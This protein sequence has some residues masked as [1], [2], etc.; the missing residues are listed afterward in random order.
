[1]S[2]KAYQDADDALWMQKNVRI[3]NK[4]VYPF[5]WLLFFIPKNKEWECPSCKWLIKS[6][7]LQ[8]IVDG[9]ES[10]QNDLN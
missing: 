9:D 8:L 3:L 7:D 4:I 10:L 2:T 6:N 5:K 1:M